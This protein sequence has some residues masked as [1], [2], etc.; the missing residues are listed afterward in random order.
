MPEPVTRSFSVDSDA[1]GGPHWS[2][3]TTSKTSKST[4]NE[5]KTELEQEQKQKRPKLYV[6]EDSQSTIAVLEKGSSQKLAHATR[7]HRGNVHWL[8]EVLTTEDVV[9]SYVASADQAADIFTKAFLVPQTWKTLCTLINVFEPCEAPIRSRLSVTSCLPNLACVALP[10]STPGSSNDP[11]LRA[12][13]PAP[14]SAGHATA[15]KKCWP[16]P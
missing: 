10:M 15:R 13:Q 14:Q 3:P 2:Q 4:S 1:G 12:G 5:K 9:L 6:F 8:S 11:S 16:M 7:T